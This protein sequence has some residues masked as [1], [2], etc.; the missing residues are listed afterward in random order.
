M[1]NY[2]SEKEVLKLDYIGTDD[3][4]RPVY[5]DQHEK[6]WKDI[7]LGNMEIPSLCSVVG[8]DFD[9]EPNSPI[10]KEF[11]IEK[12]YVKNRNR[13]EYMMLGRL[14]QDCKTHLNRVNNITPYAYK[15]SEEQQI[16]TIE[17]MKR[18]Y[19]SLADDKKPEWLTWE[20]ILEYEKNMRG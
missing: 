14:Q 5:K 15:L 8:N 13:F 10:K 4:A 12:P 19:N 7:E 1:N 3:W 11:S 2:M 20:Q 6:L 17:E 9:G 16:E 18:L